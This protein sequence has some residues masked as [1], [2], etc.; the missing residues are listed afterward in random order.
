MNMNALAQG[1]NAVFDAE[2]VEQILNSSGIDHARQ[3]LD[4]LIDQICQ[5]RQNRSVSRTEKLVESIVEYIDTHTEG[6]WLDLNNLSRQF[7]VTPQYISNVF[8]KYRDENIK[9][10]IAKRK[11]MHAKDLLATTELTVKEVAARLG[12]ANEIGV[13]RL[14]RKYEGITP[15][16]YRLQHNPSAQSKL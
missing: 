5:T 13:I 10:Y 15:G 4:S 16:N 8:K 11:L 2:F 1:E 12:Y 7:G 3:H 14:F 9:D 6:E